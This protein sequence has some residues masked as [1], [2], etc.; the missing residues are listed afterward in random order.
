TCHSTVVPYTTLFRAPAQGS[1]C[2]GAGSR[3]DGRRHAC[4]AALPDQPA[5]DSIR[6]FLRESHGACAGRKGPAAP[7]RNPG[8]VLLPDRIRRSEE[9]TSELQS[10]EKL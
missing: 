7:L 4:A 6:I 3:G 2:P 5:A 8:R 9:H 1:Y 10:R